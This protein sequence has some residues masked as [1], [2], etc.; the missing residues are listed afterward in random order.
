M[1][2][3]PAIVNIPFVTPD[4]AR[5]VH[6]LRQGR[7]VAFPTETVY[8]LGADATNP[9]AIDRIYQTKGR[10]S[11]NPLIIHVAEMDVAR[12]YVADW[13]A[14]ASR[15]ADRFWPGPLTIVL[16][17]R[18]VIPANATAGLNTVA[19]RVPDH[20][21]ALELLRAFDGPLAAPSANRSTHVSP[22]HAD[23]VRDE[24]PDSAAAGGADDREPAM[25][26]DGG[27]CGVGIESTVLDLT[28][29]PPTILR[30]GHVTPA[31]LEPI[32]GAVRLN[33][34]VVANSEP[35]TSPGQQETHYAPETPAYRFEADEWPQVA[36]L[37]AASA[38]GAAAVLFAGGRGRY[39]RQ[40]PT[41]PGAPR[42]FSTTELLGGPAEYAARIYGMLRGLD[43]A[44]HETLYIEMPPDRPEWAAVR[45]RLTRAATP[46]TLISDV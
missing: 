45:D 13:P 5:A 8:G 41:P 30:P 22:T 32:V 15:L 9:A 39:R 19:V 33:A 16:P 28:T 14:E 31:D 18:E 24:F 43:R 25:I 1:N 20:P 10:P 29:S 7:L 38:P 46:V 26:L 36:A 27:A 35:A 37:L 23:H 4:I 2:S 34:T 17:K 42:A 21:L 40:W 44:G 3:G 6:L 11:T 12:R